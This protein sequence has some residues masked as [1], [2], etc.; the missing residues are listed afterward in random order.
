MGIK[1]HFSVK[2][3]QAASRFLRSQAKQAVVKKAAKPVSK[4]KK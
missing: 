3:H 4:K 2:E 1:Y